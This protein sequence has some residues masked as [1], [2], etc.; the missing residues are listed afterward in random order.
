MNRTLCCDTV[1]VNESTLRIW[2]HIFATSCLW[3]S[4]ADC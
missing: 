4:L 1:N 3:P 2:L